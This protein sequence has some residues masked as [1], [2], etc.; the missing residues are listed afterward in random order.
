VAVLGLVL[1]AGCASQPGRERAAAER[2]PVLLS[3][4]VLELP[5]DCTAE[6]GTVYRAEYL[7]GDSGAVDRVTH[8]E[9]P[10]C[11]Q[12]A[13]ADWVN[14]FRYAPRSAP[15]AATIDWMITVARK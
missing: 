3:A 13:L 15:L 1:L 10:A 4:G 2:P 9:G 8:A 11:V 14:T 6:P 12:V 5:E 7:V